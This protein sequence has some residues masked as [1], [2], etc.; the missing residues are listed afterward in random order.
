MRR[1]V[2]LVA[3]LAAALLVLAAPSAS[4]GGPTSVLIVNYDG[5]RAAGA[6]TGGADYARLAEALDIYSDPVG[7]K[8]ASAEFMEISIRLTWM[9]HDVTPWRIDAVTIN[10]SDV[11]VSSTVRAA[12]KDLFDQESVWHRPKDAAL[13]LATLTSLGIIGE[14]QPAA[15]PEAPTTTPA[16]APAAAP[17]SAGAAT[18]STP[19]GDAARAS[20]GVPW[21]VT[22][23]AALLALGLGIVL[24][25]RIRPVTAPGSGPGGAL[26]SGH[27]PG[28]GS[29]AGAADMGAA[30]PEPV[31]PVGFTTDAGPTQR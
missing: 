20:A 1:L 23:A 26:G 16:P 7:D 28:P 21:W 13:L 30:A 15:S 18:G 31:A 27:G 14:Q 25:R 29:G 11:W 5:Q 22:A 19:G 9:I 4:A 2:A 17:G 6:L 10:G 12:D 3:A 24:G 8:R